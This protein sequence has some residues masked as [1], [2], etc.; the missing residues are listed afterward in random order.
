M[1]E[2]VDIT[3]VGLR[4]GLQSLPGVMPTADKLAWLAAE[5]ACGVQ[6][7]EVASFVPVKLLPQMADAAEVVGAAKAMRDITVTALVPNVKGATAAIDA[8]ADMLVVP[9]SA[10]EAHSRANVRRSPD[11]MVAELGRICAL[12]DQSARHVKVEA[13]IATAFGCTIQGAVAEDEVVRIAS[14][15]FAVGADEIG[16]AD[17]VGYANPAQVRR[18]FTR[19]LDM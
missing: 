7:F 16:L 18:L 17:T 2:K 1:R 12:R 13:G 19:A 15:C 11:E 4:D 9:V 6:R 5:R 14:V 8:G 3:E 10:S